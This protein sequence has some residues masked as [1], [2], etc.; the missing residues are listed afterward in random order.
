SMIST[1]LVDAGLDPTIVVGG[2]VDNFGGTNARLGSGE[3]MVVEADESDGSF[4]RLSPSIAIV[5][6]I[7][8]EHMDYYKSMRRV[9]KA[10]QSFLNKVPFY[11]LSVICGDDPYLRLM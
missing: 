2:R 5:T 8:R 4:N 10:F 6:N 3:F 9:R 11:G 7:D 1:V